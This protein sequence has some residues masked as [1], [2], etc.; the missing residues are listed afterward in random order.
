MASKLTRA[1]HA[2]RAWTNE[3]MGAPWG[4]NRLV[5]FGAL[6]HLQDDFP[7]NMLGFQD[8]LGVGDLLER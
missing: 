6:V 3:H 2:A 1:S 5:A 4:V 8:A 7:L